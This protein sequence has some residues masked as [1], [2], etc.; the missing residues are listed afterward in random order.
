MHG[1]TSRDGRLF[2]LNGRSEKHRHPTATGILAKSALTDEPV[3][4]DETSQSDDSPVATGEAIVAPV[5]RWFYKRCILLACLFAAMGL[6]FCY[7]GFFAYP[8]TNRNADIYDAFVA[9]NEGMAAPENDERS[10]DAYR[11]GIE[12][13]SWAAHAAELKLAAK[14]PGRHTADDLAT[15]K[16]LSAVFGICALLTFLWVLAHRGRAWRMIGDELQTPWNT[17]LTAGSVSDIDRR[18]WDRGVA[19]LI[20]ND[21]HRFLKLKLDDLK[22][23]DAGRIIAAI[24]ILHPEVRIDPPIAD[25]ESATAG[26]SGDN[27]RHSS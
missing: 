8:K 12:G 20:S 26:N 9:G 15:R 21:G 13:G 17:K 4:M 22:Y 24:A 5:T 18:R 10:K 7:L 23:H 19:L 6:V 11:A 14:A 3:S 1:Q 16:R 25:P 2:K 27:A